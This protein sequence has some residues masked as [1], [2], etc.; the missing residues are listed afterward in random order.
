M[1]AWLGDSV[2]AIKKLNPSGLERILSADHDKLTLLNALLQDI[3]PMAQ[4]IRG[5]ADVSPTGVTHQSIVIVAKLGGQE[6][7]DGGS[8]AIDYGAQ[9]W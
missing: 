6:R 1:N 9:M 5:G 2:D 3:R 8:H 4:V 7:G